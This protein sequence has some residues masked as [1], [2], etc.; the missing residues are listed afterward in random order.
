MRNIKLAVIA[1][2]VLLVQTATAGWFFNDVRP[3]S[4]PKGRTLDISVGHLISP[5]SVHKYPFYSL[6][7]CGSSN[8]EH[9]YRADEEIEAKEAP[10]GVSMFDDVLHESFF[11]VSY[12]QSY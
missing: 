4:Y 8:F 10:E 11:Q 7:Y 6:P 12:H 3:R 5:Q 2:I 1:S 9:H